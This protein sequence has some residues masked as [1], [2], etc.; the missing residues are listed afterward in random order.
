MCSIKCLLIFMILIY[1]TA[2]QDPNCD[3]TQNVQ[4]GQTYYVYSPQY[5]SNYTPG[6]QCRWI[7]VCPTGYR[8]KLYCPE[9]ALPQTPSCTMDRL[10]ISKTGDP[11]LSGADYYCGRGTVTALSTGQRISI[12][13]ITSYTSPGGRFMCQLFAEPASPNPP[14]TCRCGYKK[15]TRIVGGQETD[16][17]E[18]PMMVGLVDRNVGQIHCGA[19]II[20]KRYVLT[21]AHCMEKQIVSDLAVVVG[22]HDVD[23]NASPATKGYRV[24]SITIHPGYSSS[25]FS[26]D[27]AIITTQE[28]IQFGQLV[29]PA[30]LPFKFV[31]ND[32]TGN[33]VT[34]LGWGTLFPGGPVSN[35]LRKVDLDIMSQNQCKARVPS[36]TSQ[37]ICTYT[38]GKDA[39][40]DD[41]GGPL[42]Y[43][44]PST[45]LLFNIGVVSYGR[46]CA[47]QGEPG[48]NT[49]VSAYLSWIVNN[50][51]GANYCQK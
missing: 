49:R 23:S 27:I 36:L 25:T 29:G 48:V 32:M 13:L 19:V 15:Q 44:D 35:V 22:L 7:G 47:S 8:C 6:V 11:Q 24:S 34:V 5:P 51:P 31:N 33:K 18:F 45:G 20:D 1:G 12:G 38:P 30:C 40:Q 17:N 43:T 10:L 14:D 39:C 2:A 37:Q 46:F 21:A 28:D 3:F 41:S 4:P 42:L 16:V 26:N 50:T 9:V